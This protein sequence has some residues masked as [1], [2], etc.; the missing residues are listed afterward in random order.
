M[1][2]RR[3]IVPEPLF[4][5]PEA[6]VEYEIRFEL[7]TPRYASHRFDARARPVNLRHGYGPVERR[8]RGAVHA[9]EDVVK[10]EDALPVGRF[11]IPRGGVAGGYA[12]FEVIDA[13]LP[14]LHRA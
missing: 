1:P 9:D 4:E 13:W 8:H 3:G 5:L 11:V 12:G 14:P 10:I 7:L 6:G 2:G